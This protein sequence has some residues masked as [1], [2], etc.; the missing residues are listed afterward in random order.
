MQISTQEEV[1]D[2]AT[3][4]YNRWAAKK[5]NWANPE[6]LAQPRPDQ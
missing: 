4:K 2:K 5:V 1:D 6:V 3:L